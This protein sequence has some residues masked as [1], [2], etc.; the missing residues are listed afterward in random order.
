MASQEILEARAD[1]ALQS[2]S[3]SNHAQSQLCNELIPM[4]QAWTVGDYR[5]EC[6]RLSVF[7]FFIYL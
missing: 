4:W 1:D 7:L 2:G 6:R 3:Y 5:S